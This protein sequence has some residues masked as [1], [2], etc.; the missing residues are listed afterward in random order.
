MRAHKINLYKRRIKERNIHITFVIES[1]FYFKNFSKSDDKFSKMFKNVVVSSMTNFAEI[2]SIEFFTSKI[3]DIWKSSSSTETFFFIIIFLF[4]VVVTISKLI[5]FFFFCLNSAS[6][7]F[8]SFV[9]FII[10]LLSKSMISSRFALTSSRLI[11]ISSRF[12]KTSSRFFFHF[13]QTFAKANDL[14]FRTF[15]CRLNFMCD[16]KNVFFD[17]TSLLHKNN[18]FNFSFFHV[19]EDW[20][21]IVNCFLTIAFHTFC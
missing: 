16:V 8:F 5:N 18:Q 11:K 2:H 7:F 1:H 17:A 20:T 12:V 21:I 15:D 6:S 4:I 3:S 14:A 9:S 19:D 13:Y 10:V